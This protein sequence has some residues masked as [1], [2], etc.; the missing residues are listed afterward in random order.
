MRQVACPFV[1]RDGGAGREVL[2]FRH[3]RAGFQLIKGGIDADEDAETAALR[4]LREEAGLSAQSAQFCGAD[5]TIQT[6]ERWHFV[7]IQLDT[8]APDN[9]THHCAD[10]GGHLFAFAWHVLNRSLPAPADDRFVRA[11]SVIR[12]LAA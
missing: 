6:Q 5:D 1:L 8:A 4:E 2:I 12:R 9:W 11:L 7:Q 10:D 3:P